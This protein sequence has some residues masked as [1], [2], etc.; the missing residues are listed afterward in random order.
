[1]TPDRWLPTV[2]RKLLLLLLPDMIQVWEKCELILAGIVT[3]S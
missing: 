1:M 3:R 2:W